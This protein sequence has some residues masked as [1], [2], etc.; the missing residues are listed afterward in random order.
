MIC[1]ACSSESVGGEGEESGAVGVACARWSGEIAVV[2]IDGEGSIGSVS[3][4]TCGCA[5]GAIGDGGRT[6]G[7]DGGWSGG[8]ERARGAL[9]DGKGRVVECPGCADTAVVVIAAN[10]QDR[11]IGGEGDGV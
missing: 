6:G 11:A 3:G 10:K 5:C 4:C 1:R 7:V 8:G 2:A 9:W